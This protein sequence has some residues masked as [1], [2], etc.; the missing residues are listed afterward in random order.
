MQMSA[1]AN[2]L[3]QVLP[4]SEQELLGAAGRRLAVRRGEVLH[5]QGAPTRAAYFP[6]T[7]MCSLTLNLE[8]GDKAEVS[9]VGVEGFVGLS[10]YFRLPRSPAEALVQVPG[11][12]LE[13]PADAFLRLA[14]SPPLAGLLNRYAAY[15]LQYANQAV[16]CNA[17]H[18]I[19]ERACRW[20]LLTHDRVGN[21]RFELTHEFLAEML[22]V[23]RQSVTLVARS[24]QR[25]G[26]ISYTRGRVSIVDRT[27]L[28]GVSCECYAQ[29]N[30]Y[31]RETVATPIA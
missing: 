22:G 20:L 16:A 21:G 13:V 14:A 5:E 15:S 2:R 8:S 7:A 25:A 24:L 28:E 1:Y 18:S 31:Y 26:L 11:E 10:L 23:T 12:V 29:I 3:L 30:R 4:E 19:E 6:L 27:G 17:F 9:T